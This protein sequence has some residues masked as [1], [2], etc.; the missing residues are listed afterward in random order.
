M[1]LGASRALFL[2]AESSDSQGPRRQAWNCL[3]LGSPVTDPHISGL[4][5]PL[6]EPHQHPAPC[7][8][9]PSI[10]KVCMCQDPTLPGT[11]LPFLHSPCWQPLC[12]LVQP[13]STEGTDSSSMVSR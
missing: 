13:P 8:V 7:W 9:H 4:E 11:A 2:W 10:R 1:D 6:G 5:F 12:P 3:V